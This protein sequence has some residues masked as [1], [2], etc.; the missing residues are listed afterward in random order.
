MISLVS[1]AEQDLNGD[2]NA[3]GNDIINE[4]GKECSGSYNQ[5]DDENLIG[6]EIDN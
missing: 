4:Y 3:S 6:E 1:G 5:L 2:L